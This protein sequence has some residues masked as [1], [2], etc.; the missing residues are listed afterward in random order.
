MTTPE[1]RNAKVDFITRQ[2]NEGLRN[3]TLQTKRTGSTFKY[4]MCVV[5][6]ECNRNYNLP[7]MAHNRADRLSIYYV[8]R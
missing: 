7:C 6:K 2:I 4:E 1:A 5:E 8:K 3:Y